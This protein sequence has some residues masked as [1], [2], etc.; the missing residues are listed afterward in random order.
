[1]SV[2]AGI[3]QAKLS[4]SLNEK[5]RITFD[6]YERVCGALGVNTD[7]FLTPHKVNGVVTEQDRERG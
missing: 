3:P 2:K 5:R 4:L 7:R 1:M 6:E